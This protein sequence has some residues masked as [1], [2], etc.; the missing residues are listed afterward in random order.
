M[1]SNALD[2]QSFSDNA[3]II[4]RD[5]E[6]SRPTFPTQA[7]GANVFSK[8]QDAT[9]SDLTKLLLVLMKMELATAI[10]M[11]TSRKHLAIATLIQ[12]TRT[13]MMSRSRTIRR[14]LFCHASK[15]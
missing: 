14:N 2:Q 11:A 3:S 15:R 1:E 5:N 4:V 8:R 12:S 13:V 7:E 10:A 6:M 9:S